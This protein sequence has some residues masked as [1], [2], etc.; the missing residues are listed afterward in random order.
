MK[1][2]RLSLVKLLMS[3]SASARNCYR[4]RFWKS[5]NIYDSGSTKVD[6]FYYAGLG[7]IVYGEDN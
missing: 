3:A 7:Q 2:F 6:T 1:T 4:W 5:G